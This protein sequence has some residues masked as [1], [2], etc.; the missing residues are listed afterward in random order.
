MKTVSFQ[1]LLSFVFPQVL[2]NTVPGV[3]TESVCHVYNIWKQL[4][5]RFQI[6]MCK[7]HMWMN[8]RHTDIS[9]KN[10]SSSDLIY[11]ETKIRSLSSCE[12]PFVWALLPFSEHSSVC[13][14]SKSNFV[15]SVPLSSHHMKVIEGS[16]NSVAR[17]KA[18]IPKLEIFSFFFFSL[19]TV[20][21]FQL[22][23]E[24]LIRLPH[25]PFSMNTG[26]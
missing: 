10:K 19:A 12:T 25:V 11:S 4:P 13:S 20:F 2:W 15:C 7:T 22:W 23:Q 9:S 26:K 14:G 24:E 18:L 6:Q 3:L 8:T 17:I 21:F 16:I 1:T 5:K